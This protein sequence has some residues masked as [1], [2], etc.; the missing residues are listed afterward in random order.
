M[1][2]MTFGVVH[3]LDPSGRVVRTYRLTSGDGSEAFAH[4]MWISPSGAC[5]TVDSFHHHIVR[6]YNLVVAGKPGV[7]R[8]G[9]HR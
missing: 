7:D 4:R 9:T 1:F 2:V 5:Y 3:E 8:T 6:R